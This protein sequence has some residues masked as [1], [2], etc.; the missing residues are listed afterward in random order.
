M[1][2][3]TPGAPI[4]SQ[5]IEAAIAR[6]LPWAA[7]IRQP[8]GAWLNGL[9]WQPD[10]V[11]TS[12]AALPDAP[13]FTVMVSGSE[14]FA[15]Q[16]AVRDPGTGVAVLR[17]AGF[18]PGSDLLPGDPPAPGTVL[19]VI[20][21][22]GTPSD[23]T[24]DTPNDTPTGRLTTV[25]DP[26]LRL[27]SPPGYLPEGGTVVNESGHVVGLCISATSGEPHLVPYAT[28]ARV[29]EGHTGHA[30]RGWMGASFQPVTLSE[31]DA[32]LTG[33]ETG[34]LVVHVTPGGPAE[35]AGLRHGDIILAIDGISMHGHGTLRS[36]LGPERLGRPCTLSILRLGT[37][38]DVTMVIKP[39]P[40]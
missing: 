3:D 40:A 25:P 31:S 23:T 21:R 20:D 27:D 33:Q 32:A 28:L 10:L 13:D 39:Q 15:A 16:I 35:E 11:L 12:S 6:A 1:D 9:Y 7:G 34:R 14:V 22:S 18:G 4:W 24:S 29:R 38:M 37:L 8:S 30:S 19:L 2:S 5:P 17:L 36:F 26:T